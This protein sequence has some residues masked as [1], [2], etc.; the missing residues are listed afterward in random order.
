LALSIVPMKES[1][2]DSLAHLESLCFSQ[3]WSRAA[4]EEELRNP[5]ALFLVAESE[6]G[7][8]LGYAGMHCVLGECYMD[9]IA[10]FPQARRRG[11][12]KGLLEALLVWMERHDA[13]FLT[14]EVRSSNEAAISL[15]RSLG[16]EEVGRRPGFYSSPR[17]DALLFTRQ[18]KQP[19]APG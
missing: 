11:V 7:A 12:A 8:V 9:N 5:N 19:A 16:F 10:V 14:L 4:L 6:E 1:H 3:P 15:Y 18:Q 2:L 17:E 13:L